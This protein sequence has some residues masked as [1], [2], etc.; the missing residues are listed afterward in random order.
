[1]IKRIVAIL[2]LFFSVINALAEEETCAT[3]HY[4]WEDFVRFFDIVYSA[5]KEEYLYQTSN[6]FDLYLLELSEQALY[7]E[8]P[9]YNTIQEYSYDNEQN[10]GKCVS[11]TLRDGSGL[12]IFI[13]DGMLEYVYHMVKRC[14]AKEFFDR[15]VLEYSTPDDVVNVD[16]NAVFNP[17]IQRGPCSYHCLSD[18]TF[19]EITYKQ[20]SLSP[21]ILVV[22][23]IR[24]VS[25][26]EALPTL[27]FISISDMP[28]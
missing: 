20:S 13:E 5:E 7:E 22:R 23:S 16:K 10:C 2:L 18:D 19:W 11:Y 25:Q 14:T 27:G 26:D 24:A 12:F 21:H 17:L 6:T 4:S 3:T 28:K 8:F 15:I 1:M 9:V